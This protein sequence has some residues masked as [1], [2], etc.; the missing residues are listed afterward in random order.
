MNVTK[1]FTKQEL[2][3]DM[4]N[5]FN[6]LSSPQGGKLWAEI[7]DERYQELL[8]LLIKMHVTKVRSSEKELVPI[9]VNQIT[10][11]EISI[12]TDQALRAMDIELFEIQIWRSMGSNY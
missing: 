6:Q 2:E 8:T 1:G 12:F 7:D 4:A 10:Q 11:T 5:L 9:V 3:V